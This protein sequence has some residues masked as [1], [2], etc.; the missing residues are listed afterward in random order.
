MQERNALQLDVHVIQTLQQ[1][2]KQSNQPQGRHSMDTG[3]RLP[4][5]CSS[6]VLSLGFPH[7][8]LPKLL[9]A[10]LTGH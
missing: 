5:N 3:H 4:S 1:E 6:L 8:A 2:E 10:Q 7:A 9:S